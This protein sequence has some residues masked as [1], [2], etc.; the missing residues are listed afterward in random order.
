M[1]K[2]QKDLLPNVAKALIKHTVGKAAMILFNYIL[3]SVA[4]ANGK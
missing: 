2:E 1:F 4:K 3:K